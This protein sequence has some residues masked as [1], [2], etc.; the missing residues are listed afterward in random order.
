[1]LLTRLAAEATAQFG[2]EGRVYEIRNDFFG[3][4]ITVAGLVTGRDLIAQLKGK[5][6][7]ERLLLPDCMLRYHQNVFL[8]DVTV[9]QVE[10]A[11]GVPVTF[12]AQ[13]G[14]K[15]LDAILETEGTEEPEEEDFFPEDDEY[16][17]YNPDR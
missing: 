14:F 1:P 9:E 10:A 16:F 4:E 3:P 7:G 6:L 8:D 13:D 11:L 12:V 17:R 5:E 15:L 2:G